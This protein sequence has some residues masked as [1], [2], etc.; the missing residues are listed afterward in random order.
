MLTGSAYMREPWGL[1]TIYS[2][3][4]PKY[5]GLLYIEPSKLYQMSKLA[6]QNDLQ[7]TAHSVGDGAVHALIDAYERISTQDFPVRDKRPCIT[8]CNFMS[9]EAIERMSKV[10]IVADLQPAWLFLDGK[11]LLK[12]FGQ[13]RTAF[14]Q[15]YRNLADAK[16]IVGGGSDHMQ[17]IG[18]FRSVNPYNPF[19]GMSVAIERIPRGM[20]QPLHREQ[21]ISRQEAIRLYTRNNAYL[22]F[23]EN[24]KGSIEPGKLADFIILDRDILECPLDQIA[25]TKVLETY[26][27][28]KLVYRA[29]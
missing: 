25:S 6:L 10:G 5:R 24:H 18:S 28:G 27:G 16:V 22:T 1:S 8:H 14:F 19:L 17:R 11:T 9:A 15:P 2:I 7:F 13:E 3:T 26:V 21:C 29:E 20:D 12:Q 4:D 23:E